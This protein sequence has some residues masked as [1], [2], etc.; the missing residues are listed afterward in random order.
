MPDDDIVISRA[1]NLEKLEFR[2]EGRVLK[3][4]LR[5]DADRDPRDA[6]M[7][8]VVFHPEILDIFLFPGYAAEVVDPG[9][10]S[11]MLQVAMDGAPTQGKNWT[12]EVNASDHVLQ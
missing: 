10:V 7:P 11:P 2:P 12:H 6:E 9:P 3:R 5:F 1:V 8:D 4:E